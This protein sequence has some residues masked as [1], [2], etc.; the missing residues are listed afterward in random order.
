MNKVVLSDS[1]GFYL[2]ATLYPDGGLRFDG[3]RLSGDRQRHR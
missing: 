3:Q 2:E 1:G